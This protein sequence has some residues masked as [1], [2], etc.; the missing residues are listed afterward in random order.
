MLRTRKEYVGSSGIFHGVIDA[1]MGTALEVLFCDGS[2]EARE[3]LW[4]WLCVEAGRIQK[5]AD[6]FNPDSELSVLNRS[7]TPLCVGETLSGMIRMAIRY[8]RLT[9]GLFDVAKGGLQEVS[10]DDSGVVTLG[11]HDLDFGGMAKGLLLSRLRS[12]AFSEGIG[13]LF[14]DFG[15]S[16]IL[17][18]GHHPYGECWSVG[19][20]NPFRQDVLEEVELRNQAMSTSGNTPSYGSHIINPLNGEPVSAHRQVTV[21]SDDAL[22]AEVLSTALMI[23][24]G[25][26]SKRIAARFPGCIIKDYEV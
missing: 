21:V 12:A 22:D 11:E 23:A 2:P 8:H 6:R 15:G 9:D 5:A 24:V 3:R 19:V 1:V 20:R 25:D 10:I 13:S 7:R 18:L 26:A 4:D 16:S 14:A 17:A